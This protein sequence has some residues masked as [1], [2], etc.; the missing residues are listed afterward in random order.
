M[1][2]LLAFLLFFGTCVQAAQTAHL[3]FHDKL[4]I[5]LPSEL[6]PLSA[7]ALSK[8]YGGQKLPPEYV[9]SNKEQDISFTF[10]RYP[11][12]ADKQNMRKIHKSISNMLRGANPK[13]KWKKD[14]IYSRF[15]T[16]VAVYEYETKGK[17]QFQYHLTY[18]LP[19][20]GKLTFITF[21]ITDKK[22][23]NRWLALARQSMDSI[24]F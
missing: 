24:Q 15:N 17:N 3:L 2:I 16:K 19:V 4:T 5:H 9:F 18:A 13:A 6:K 11:M 10:T 12:V 22:Y 23:K 14:K 1:K 20:D 21:V 8:R 7:A